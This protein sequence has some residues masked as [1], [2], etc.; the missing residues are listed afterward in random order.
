MKQEISLKTESTLIRRKKI[1]TLDDLA[2][3]LHCSKRTVQRRLTQ[4]KTI[5]S[6]NRNGRYYTLEDIGK[7]DAN[8]LWRYRGT[9]FSRFGN[10][11]QTFVQLVRASQSGLTSH[12]AGDLIGL[13]P[14]S[15]IWNFHNHPEIK[16]QK[17][18]GRYVYFSSE[19]ARYAQQF[20]NRKI[21]RKTQRLP[22]EFEAIAILVEKIKHPQLSL[23]ELADK[24]KGKKL[25][26]EPE[27]IENL[28]L[29][30]GLMIKKNHI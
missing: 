5:R 11:T 3:S 16:R 27:V 13:R 28:F 15:F 24:L 18:Q 2:N 22:S 26:I 10:L 1:V 9:C 23:E 17:H 14:S 7:F 25:N 19:P 12:E 8:G 29:H 30:H 4:L 20:Q 6:Y 21:M